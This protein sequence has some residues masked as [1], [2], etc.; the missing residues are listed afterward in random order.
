[1]AE[2]LVVHDLQPH[3]RVVLELALC[4][5]P[6]VSVA[7][8][9]AEQHELAAALRRAADCV[10]DEVQPLLRDEA[11]HANDERLVRVD[12]E[13]KALLHVLLHQQLALRGARGTE[14]QRKVRVALG[15]PEHRVDPVEDAVVLL[16]VRREE[17]PHPARGTALKRL[18]RVRRAHRRHV[19]RVDDAALQ[20]RHALR[21]V[22]NR[23]LVH[24]LFHVHVLLAVH[25]RGGE[26]LHAAL[27]RVVHVVDR[28][29]D[30]RLVER[31]LAVVHVPVKHGRG[32]RLPLVQMQDVRLRAA[33]LEEL[34]R[35]AA[36]VEVR[37]ELVV[38]A[39]VNLAAAEDVP[40][41]VRLRAQEHHLAP[42][43]GA[44]VHGRAHALERDLAVEL[45]ALGHVEV[46]LVPQVLHL[47]HVDALVEGQHHLDGVPALAHGAR[48]ARDDVAKAAHLGERRELRGDVHDVH[49]VVVLGDARGGRGR[50][51][52]ARRA[53]PEGG[54]RFGPVDGGRVDGVGGNRGRRGDARGVG[55]RLRALNWVVRRVLDELLH[56]GAER[57]V[58]RLVSAAR[59]ACASRPSVSRRVG[60]GPP[61]VAPRAFAHNAPP[62][63]LP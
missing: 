41:V 12:V 4:E 57:F 26:F 59:R 29:H 15:V 40:C 50:R 60:G 5:R 58:F 27:A 51:Q 20:Q 16:L 47:V 28:Q 35:R 56:R 19:V 30:A 18:L 1:M 6:E 8:T 45:E 2:R 63:R 31:A 52:G 54:E 49:A 34:E 21:V 13:P 17:L 9:G 32:A 10:A 25:A 39:P 24:R 33:R 42:R 38:P 44:A 53:L 22:P 48:E 7:V 36:E 61:V 3:V 55:L 46:A 43:D 11:R 37:L 62:P 23:P 14:A